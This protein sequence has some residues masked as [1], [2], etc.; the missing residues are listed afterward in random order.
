VP[1]QTLV[2]V[3]PHSRGGGT[4]RRWKQLEARVREALGSL[5]VEHTQAPRDAER[6]AREAVRAGVERILVAGG[7]GTLSEVVTGLLAA[8]LGGYAVLGLLPLGTGGDFA[9]SLGVPVDLDGALAGLAAGKVRPVDA[10]RVSYRD[11]AGRVC[12]RY[13]VN[14][15]SLGVSGL[16]TQLVNQAPK[17]LGGRL[18]FLIGTLRALARWRCR[19]V[20]LE[21]DGQVV[22]EGPIVL[23]AV[24]NGRYFGGGMQVAP[25]A[26]I[27]DGLLEVVVVPE[28]SRLELL[29]KLPRI[30]AGTH[31]EDPAIGLHRG[32]KL[33]ARA[34]PG[35]VPVEIDGEPLGTLPLTVEVLP[36]ALSVIGPA[37]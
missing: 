18:S 32:R 4:G 19:P 20:T 28:L 10:A 11:G 33:E 23:A 25:Q 14:V 29:R 1:V 24:A 2:I 15:A 7:D 34:E 31:L 9:R 27:D 17:L 6:I 37:D 8:G 13:L 36:G 22:F 26:L 12:T 30:Y 35:S 5:E 21:V 3:N 16:V